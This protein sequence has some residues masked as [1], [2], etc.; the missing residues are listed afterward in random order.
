MIVRELAAGVQLVE[1]AQPA[2]RSLGHRDRHRAVQ[3]NDRGATDLRQA[4]VQQ[5]DARPV[6]GV[7]RLCA[8]VLGRDG[9]LEPV[10][11]LVSGLRG[12]DQALLELVT[13]PE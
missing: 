5:R 2:L 6:G 3:L 13:P 1:Q 10:L 4:L 8:G 7:R 11:T 12:E 9:R